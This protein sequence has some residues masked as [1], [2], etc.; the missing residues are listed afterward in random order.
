MQGCRFLKRLKLGQQVRDDGPQ[1]HLSKAGTPTMGG[2]IIVIAFVVTTMIFRT[3]DYKMILFALG[4][5]LGFCLIGLLDDMIIVVRKRSMG[6]VRTRNNRAGRH[7][8]YCGV[9]R[10]F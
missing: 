1:T 5:T 10:I 6:S 9:I 4:V 3:G 8:A 7:S 2:I